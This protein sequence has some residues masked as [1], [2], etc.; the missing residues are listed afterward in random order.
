MYSWTPT[1]I[2]LADPTSLNITNVGLT[3]M[4]LSWTAASPTTG[5]TGYAILVSTDGGT[6]YAPFGSVALG[7]NTFNATGLTPNTVYTFAIHSYGGESTLSTNPTTATQ[8]TNTCAFSGV[9]PFVP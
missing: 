6:T 8:A 7:T 5:V 9:I 4:T 2:S 3:S 1:N